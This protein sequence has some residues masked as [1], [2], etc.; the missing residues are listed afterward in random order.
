MA[1][2]ALAALA[3]S[4][5]FN[6]DENKIEIMK[7]LVTSDKDQPADQ[8]TFE[9]LK[10]IANTIFNHVQFTTDTPSIHQEGMCPLL[11]LQILVRVDILIK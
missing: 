10:K 1:S 8:R 3:P 2:A 5:R 9:E 4:T 7:N 6:K 11:D